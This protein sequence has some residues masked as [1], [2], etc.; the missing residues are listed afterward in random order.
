MSFDE[1]ADKMASA[2]FR[3]LTQ[4]REKGIILGIEK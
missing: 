2:R 3:L 4:E 1:M